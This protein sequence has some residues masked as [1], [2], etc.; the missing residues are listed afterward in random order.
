MNFIDEEHIAGFEIGENG[1][2]IACPLDGRAGGDTH[3]DLHLVGDDVRKAGL[4]QSRRAIKQDVIQRLAAQPSGLNQD[5]QI[6]FQAL[7]AGKLGEQRRTQG[8]IERGV[9]FTRLRG[10]GPIGHD[11]LSS[12]SSESIILDRSHRP[13]PIAGAFPSRE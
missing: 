9:F 3:I 7:L 13:T 11:F 6:L 4:A 2:Q 12:S 8:T 1:S 10:N 5:A